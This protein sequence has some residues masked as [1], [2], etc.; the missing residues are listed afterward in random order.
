MQAQ[1]KEYVFPIEAG[2]DN[3]TDSTLGVSKET[4]PRQSPDFS[5]VGTVG[6]F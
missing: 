1:A 4:P 3:G 2:K 6:D 5:P